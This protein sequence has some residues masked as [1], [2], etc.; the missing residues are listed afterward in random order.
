MNL[1]DYQKKGLDLIRESKAKRILFWLATG[2][3][4]SLIIYSY[5]KGKLDQGER[6]V[7]IMRRRQLV[8]QIFE[9]LEKRGITGSIVMASNPNFDE[10][11]PLQVCSIDTLT[12]RDIS[13]LSGSVAVVDEAHD[14]TSLKY[15]EVLEK[16]NAPQYLGLTATPFPVGKKI[17]D[18]WDECIKPIETHELRNQ[19]YLVPSKIF[20]P[21]VIDF[22]SVKQSLGDYNQA[23][24]E[25]IM[26]DLEIVGDVV[27][28]YQE[29]G[30]GKRAILFAV[31][32]EHSKL[33]ARAFESVGIPAIHCD[34]SSGQKE[35]DFAI[36]LFKRD[37]IKILCNVNIFSTGVDIPSA[38]VG[39]MARPTK[40]EVLWIQQ[41]GRLL[42]PY[43]VCGNCKTEYDNSP[44]C[45]K[46]KKDMPSIIKEK[47]I[48]LDSSANTIRLG[49]PY[50]VRE[51]VLTRKQFKKKKDAN[52][53]PVKI[54]DSC[55]FAY[56]SHVKKCPNCGL[57]NEAPKNT[58]EI[59]TKD[60]VLIEYEDSD[61][62]IPIE[63][64]IV[65]YMASKKRQQI[66]CGFKDSYYLFK[67]YEK[68][69]DKV[70]D[71][72]MVEFPKWVAKYYH[73]SNGKHRGTPE[74][75][76]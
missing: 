43:R 48:I 75:A 32:I 4:K 6:V 72:P 31:T 60:G 49:S 12:R 27:R 67:T 51:A 57:K 5:I 61:G 21:K 59:E 9:T 35:R 47:A 38:E 7:L 41:L 39:I 76:T 25:R 28:E 17:H 36:D 71:Y 13:F 14:T 15:R 2:G 34:Q 26:S 54:C 45:P 20:V 10:D 40:S 53:L 58:R 42:R 68:F 18:F 50:Q 22:S 66:H 55:F 46:C 44:Q 74:T 1:R 29:K 69:K 3:G 70:Y 73:K 65:D 16:I 37:K 62:Y 19:G 56:L 30:E 11:N 52:P 33:M 8:F 23:E 24:I 64:K 63:R